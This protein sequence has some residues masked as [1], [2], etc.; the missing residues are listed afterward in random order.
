MHDVHVRH[1]DILLLGF[2]NVDVSHVG[3]E[4]VKMQF[5]TLAAV[6]MTPKS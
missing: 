5:T 1:A 2:Y 4:G 3:S 6:L